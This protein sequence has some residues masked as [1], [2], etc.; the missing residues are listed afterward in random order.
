M[1]YG[2]DPDDYFPRIDIPLRGR[3]P[4]PSG[5][6]PSDQERAAVQAVLKKHPKWPPREVY[7]EI[8]LIR[9]DIPLDV[10]EVVVAEHKGLIPPR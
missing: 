6:V 9:H 10:V 7:E 3:R 5:V 2:N 8:R 1:Q 4:V